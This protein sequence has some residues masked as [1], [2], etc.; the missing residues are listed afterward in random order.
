MTTDVLAWNAAQALSC[1][2]DFTDEAHGFTVAVVIVPLEPM[3]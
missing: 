3:T 1:Q 2:V